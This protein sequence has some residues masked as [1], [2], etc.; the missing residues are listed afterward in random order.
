MDNITDNLYEIFND[1]D[2]WGYFIPGSFFGLT[3]FITYDFLLNKK[4]NIH[5]LGTPV[6]IMF[7]LL[8]CYFFGI[9]LHEIGSWLQTRVFYREGEASEL[10]LFP[11][12][13]ILNNKVDRNVFLDII[14][15]SDFISESNKDRLAVLA[16]LNNFDNN[17]NEKEELKALCR[18]IINC[19]NAK[20]ALS[21][22]SKLPNKMHSIKG[23]SRS[24]FFSL[25]IT[26]IIT[27]IL[28][29]VDTAF[30][31]EGV[32][33][34]F[35]AISLISHFICICCLYR[36]VKRFDKHWVVN[37]CRVYYSSRLLNS[38]NLLNIGNTPF[39]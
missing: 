4:L 1:F 39:V 26:G 34:Y 30:I 27:I 9:V 18:I 35:L 24:L 17:P 11:G 13:D 23:L 19:I 37:A 7:F 29:V 16:T 10:F 36:R 8:L 22:L 3:T 38:N 28:T 2:I 20:L 5:E 14:Y 21:N 32:N 33:K 12:N 6:I 25:I 15:S 31:H